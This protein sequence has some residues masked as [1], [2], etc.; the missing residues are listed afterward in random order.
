MLLIQSVRGPWWRCSPIIPRL[1]LS[2]AYNDNQDIIFQLWRNYSACETLTHYGIVFLDLAVCKMMWKN[3]IIAEFGNVIGVSC[4]F[5]ASYGFE[6]CLPHLKHE[7]LGGFFC[8]PLGTKANNTA[9]QT[10]HPVLL[11]PEHSFL[12]LYFNLFS[13][14][15][16]WWS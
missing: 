15:L 7:L 5:S 12:F 4:G 6:A 1:V 16:H 3:M 9:T 10:K 13:L 2:T 8:L 14:T 11:I